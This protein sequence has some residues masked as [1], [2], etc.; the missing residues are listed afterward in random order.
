MTPVS[1]YSGSDPVTVMVWMRASGFSP[2]L[3]ATA[4]L[5][6]ITAALPSDSGEL[7]PGVMSHLICGNRAAYASL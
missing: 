4:P 3:R 2:R 5:V 7:L 6:I 1:M